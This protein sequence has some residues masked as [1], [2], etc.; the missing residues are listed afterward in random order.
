MNSFDIRKQCEEEYIHVIIRIAINT[1][2]NIM[3][4]YI[5]IY[6]KKGKSCLNPCSCIQ[7]DSSMQFFVNT[8]YFTFTVTFIQPGVCIYNFLQIKGQTLGRCNAVP[9]MVTMNLAI[10]QLIGN[11]ILN[12]SLF[13]EVIHLET[14]KRGS[15]SA[16][17]ASG[18]GGRVSP[19]IRRKT[20]RAS[21]MVISRFTFSPDSTGRKKPRNDTA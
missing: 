20:T 5:Y 13:Q 3:I 12:K 4:I 1:I 14:I 17:M 7:F 2:I 16:G 18:V 9:Y 15:P 11:C 10:N 8:I 21:N 19:T 6:Q